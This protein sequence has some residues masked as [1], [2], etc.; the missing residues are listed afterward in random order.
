MYSQACNQTR[1]GSEFR[2]DVDHRVNT[3]YTTTH[4]HPHPSSS[5][6]SGHETLITM[7]D[8]PISVLGLY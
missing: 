4:I 1:Q 7:N 5:P 8:L 3:P 6:P 2:G